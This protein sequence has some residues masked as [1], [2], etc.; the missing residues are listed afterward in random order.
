MKYTLHPR[1]RGERRRAGSILRA[2]E[3]SSAGWRRSG[4][5]NGFSTP[6]SARSEVGSSHSNP[7]AERIRLGGVERVV[8]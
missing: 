3:S 2:S 5:L 4:F 7:P 1:S 6:G 8:T